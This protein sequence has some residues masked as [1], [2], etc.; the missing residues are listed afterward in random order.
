M[1]SKPA[2]TLPTEPVPVEPPPAEPPPEVAAPPPPHRVGRAILAAAAVVVVAFAAIAATPFWAPAVIQ[3]LPWGAAP[4]KPQPQPAL[5]PA[6]ALPPAPATP[7][8]DPALAVL[9][10]QS[11]QNAAAL[12]A[13]GQQVAALAAKP[14]PD[15]AP[16]QQQVA[17]LSAS[18]AD[19]TQK[20]AALD[21]AA[22]AGPADAAAL[23]L[24]LLQ[25]EQAVEIGRP[26]GAEY[27]ALITLSRDHPDIAAATTPLAA[28]AASGVA[29][30]AV[31]IARLHQLAPRIA[32]AAPPA[33]PGW[34]SQIV[35]RL[36]SLVTIRRIDGD[37]QSP[38]EAAVSAAES[39]LA[40]GDLDAAITAL[41]AL[42]GANLAAA[43]PW[44]GMARQRFE[45][46]TVL[47]RIETLITAELGAAPAKPG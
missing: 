37:G 3:L 11:A 46:E 29:S 6:A 22:Q 30:R 10:T 38:A 47:Q 35:A 14:A 36:R 28:P 17:S 32:D 18:V 40:G 8:P 27:R 33:E 23:A 19:L 16:L 13:L 26:F 15:L 25:I 20:I 2:D 9:K 43:Q 31:L 21:K 4:A 5:P 34:R 45:V 41:S 1:R 7:A 24:V 12:Q 44:L 42:D 39:A